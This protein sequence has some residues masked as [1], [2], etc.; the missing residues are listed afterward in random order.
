LRGE[1]LRNDG[2]SKL[3]GQNVGKNKL[4][5]LIGP[6]FLNDGSLI[7]HEFHDGP[8]D[9]GARLIDNPA[10]DSAVHLLL[11]LLLLGLRQRWVECDGKTGLSSL[12]GRKR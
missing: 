12:G 3:P 4:T 8:S 6:N 1:A 11:G 7:P 5:I 9:A 2:A 10:A